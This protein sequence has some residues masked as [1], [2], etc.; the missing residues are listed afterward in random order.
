[1]RALILLALLC[2]ACG[3]DGAPNARKVIRETHAREVKKLVTE[4]V[5]RHLV[6]VEKAAERI[7]RGFAVSDPTEREAQ[8]RTAL[9]LLTKPPRGIPELIASARSF[10]AA[11]EPS[12]VVLA[13]DAPKDRDRMTG[14][15]LGDEFQ[16]VKNALAGQTGYAIDQFPAIEKD[17]EGSVSLL[18]AAPSRKDGQVIGAVLTGIPLWKLSQRL[19]KQLQLDHAPELMKGAVIWVY[20]YREP[21]LHYFATPPDLDTLVPDAAARKAGLSRS[22]GG[23]TAEVAQYGRW[24]AYGVLPL[25]LLGPDTGVVIF[26]SDPM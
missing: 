10:T 19:G 14:V 16:L 18:F 12:G 2:I 5:Q 9:R 13:T 22:A 3:P 7:V 21:Q 25:R 15:N 11:I 1:M 4:D 8:M 20:V 26:R 6:G 24:Y 23:F 17:S